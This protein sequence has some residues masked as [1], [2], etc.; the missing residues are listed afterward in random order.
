VPKERRPLTPEQREIQR[1]VLIF[2]PIAIVVVL[3][4][5]FLNLQHGAAHTIGLV[6]G[7]PVI[8]VLLVVAIRTLRPKNPN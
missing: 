8:V 3:L 6:I 1:R 5:A 7:I 4:L 2:S